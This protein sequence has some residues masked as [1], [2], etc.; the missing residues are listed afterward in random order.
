MQLRDFEAGRSDDLRDRPIDIAP[1]EQELI[2][3]IPP[4]LPS[5]GGR[6]VCATVLQKAELPVRS[7]NAMN[8]AERSGGIVDHA[9]GP[10]EHH[11]IEGGVVERQALAVVNAD[12]D[13][14]RGVGNSRPSKAK[15]FP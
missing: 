11:D 8:F 14:K 10:R 13:R 7:Q 15:R 9:Q 6:R 1:S 12:P 2:Q 4:I 3:R 5:R